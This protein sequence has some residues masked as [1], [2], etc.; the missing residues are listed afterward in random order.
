MTEDYDQGPST[1]RERAS[2]ALGLIVSAGLLFWA[3][4]G[5]DFGEAIR[6]VAKAD[7]V[8]LAVAVLTATITL[9]MRAWRWR[10]LLRP[11]GRVQGFSPLFR[12]LAIGIMG[13]NVLPARTGEIVRAYASGCLTDAR[14][15]SGLASIA[16]ERAMDLTAILALLA[17]A[18]VVG[19]VELSGEA[20]AGVPLAESALTAACLVVILLA[21]AW[22]V[23]VR[24][25]TAR[26][27]GDRFGSALGRVSTPL[28]R[29]IRRVVD[30]FVKGISALRRPRLAISAV[31]WTLGI[32]I[33][34]AAAF[35]LGLHSFGIHVGWTAPLLLQSF[36]ALSIALPSSP[37]FFGPF[38]AAGRIALGLYGIEATRA[39]S[40]AFSF[41]LVAYFVPVVIVGF[42]ALARS[43]LTLSSL[44]QGGRAG[45]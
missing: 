32:W 10:Y 8:W 5:V 28:E 29:G 30:D 14:M 44:R 16:V 21:V 6:H 13:N 22:V 15:A 36:V 4:H 3:L 23:A 9:P 12:S 42:W 25:E 1:G 18:L 19:G 27:V 45:A 38:E 31:A 37:G 11:E 24:P 40:F 34:N 43:P 33:T 2:V 41:H 20:A 35:W 17:L 7:P 26:A 39:V